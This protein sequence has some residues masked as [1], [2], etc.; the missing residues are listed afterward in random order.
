MKGP[1]HAVSAQP[2]V[3]KTPAYRVRLHGRHRY[4]RLGD[5]WLRR[6]HVGG[7]CGGGGHC[8]LY[9][10]LREAL[11]RDDTPVLRGRRGAAVG[12]RHRLGRLS[13][14]R[15]GHPQEPAGEDDRRP[16]REDRAPGAG[17]VRPG[18]CPGR[19]LAPDTHPAHGHGAH[20]GC[21]AGNR[22]RACSRACPARARGDD[23]ARGVARKCAAQACKGGRRSHHGAGNLRRGASGGGKGHGAS[24]CLAR[25]ARCDLRGSLRGRSTLH[26][27]HGLV[28]RGLGK[29][30]QELHGA[31]AC[32][33]C[34]PC[35]RAPRRPCLPHPCDRHGP[36]YRP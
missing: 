14:G 6:R 33:R 1:A 13:R 25:P 7:D 11:P 23:R 2:L 30:A 12:P 10:R 18:T 22:R 21:G 26:G 29:R 4:G 36:G 24:C 31:H 5:L 3:C 20:P 34:H 16:A 8:L 17:E 27:R 9:G 15:P 28:G 35:E 32:R 19:R